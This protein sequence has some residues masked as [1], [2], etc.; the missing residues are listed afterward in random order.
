V[1]SD[2]VAWQ[3]PNGWFLALSVS[4][5]PRLKEFCSAKIGTDLAGKLLDEGAYY[6]LKAK[7]RNISSLCIQSQNQMLAIAYPSIIRK[8]IDPIIPTGFTLI[9]PFAQTASISNDVL[10]VFM[11]NSQCVDIPLNDLKVGTVVEKILGKNKIYI[12]IDAKRIPL[13]KVHWTRMIQQRW[14]SIYTSIMLQSIWLFL[15]LLP[16]ILFGKKV[17]FQYPPYTVVLALLAT[18]IIE[19]ILLFSILDATSWPANQARYI[20]PV[21][22]LYSALIALSFATIIEFCKQQIIKNEKN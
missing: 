16:I 7:N 15:V 21:M 20:Y 6:W 13:N 5:E 1:R 18:A 11:E 12:G 2:V 10:K 4:N 8:D 14:E 17:G 3:N 9:Y 22:P 19:R